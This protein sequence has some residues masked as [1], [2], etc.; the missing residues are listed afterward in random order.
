MHVHHWI[1][2]SPEPGQYEM[3]AKCAGCGGGRTFPSV[4][5]LATGYGGTMTDNRERQQRRREGRQAPT[6]VSFKHYDNTH[7]RNPY[8]TGYTHWDL[9]GKDRMHVLDSPHVE[10]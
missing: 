2:E 8:M 1:V 5:S 10:A 6:E 3:Q 4:R 9:L 7:A